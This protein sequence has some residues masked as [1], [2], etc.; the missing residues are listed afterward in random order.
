MQD[1]ACT[2]APPSGA[3]TAARSGSE[4]GVSRL[5]GPLAAA[6]RSAGLL[7][8]CARVASADAAHAVAA[9]TWTQV[10]TAHLE[11]LTDAG[12]AVGERVAARLE[13]LRT[14]LAV[15]TPAL[16]VDA[17]PV[18]VIVFRDASLASAYAPTWRGLHDDVAG[19]FHAGP[20]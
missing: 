5:P 2:P 20:D 17:S 18:Q 12:R 10:E 13:D 3:R 6:L 15:L 16:V 9:E 14:A 4:G 19:F 8:L 7:G 11:V 1:P